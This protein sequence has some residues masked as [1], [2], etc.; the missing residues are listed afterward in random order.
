M[1]VCVC[2][3]PQTCATEEEKGQARVDL[4]LIRCAE[5]RR[6]NEGN[7]EVQKSGGD[8]AD[9]GDHQ[10]LHLCTYSHRQ[11]GAGRGAFTPKADDVQTLPDIYVQ[12]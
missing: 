11:L 12:T 1:C 10:S 3:R 6:T 8:G 4:T 5:R 9:P 2:V 7:R